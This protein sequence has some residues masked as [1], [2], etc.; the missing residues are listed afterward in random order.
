MPKSRGKELVPGQKKRGADSAYRR[1]LIR[2]LGDG[3]YWLHKDG[4]NLGHFKTEVAAKKAV[5]YL[6]D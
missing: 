3:D 6:I 4:F 2:Y 1:Y 5:D